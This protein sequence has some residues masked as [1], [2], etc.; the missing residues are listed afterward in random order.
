MWFC[1]VPSRWGYVGLAASR[2][3]LERVTS[4]LPTPADVQRELGC[5][6][7]TPDTLAGAEEAPPEVGGY[8]DRAARW[9]EEYCRD[10]VAAAPASLPDLAWERVSAFAARVYNVM[11][12]I[13][14][15]ET[16]AYGQVA[17]LLGCPRSAR[18]VGRACARNP[19][20]LMVPCHRVVGS[21]D[22]G[23]FGG[24]RALKEALLSWEREKR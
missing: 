22:L 17:A 23:G 18:A 24:G 14:A 12:A 20:P 7:V 15:G 13:P 6:A 5:C 3:G 4:P 10:P 11:L 16:L 9:I 21:R 2:R 1:V 8:L 19:W